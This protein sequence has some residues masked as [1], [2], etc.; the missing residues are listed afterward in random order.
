MHENS[1][2]IYYLIINL[3]T[4]LVW[5]ADKRRAV[6]QQWRVPEKWL[7]FLALMGG[8]AG[9]LAGM[10]LFRHK[11]RKPLFWLT[12]ILF[13]AVHILFFIFVS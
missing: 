10:I 5:E 11:I 7:F 9:A 3:V 6:R 8:A 12:G 2:L 1:I 4:L 13:L